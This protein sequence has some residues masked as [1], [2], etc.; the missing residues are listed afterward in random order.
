M[1]KTENSDSKPSRYERLIGRVE[2]LL[3]VTP[4]EMRPIASV[5]V[6]RA[7]WRLDADG[8]PV[9]KAC[10]RLWNGGEF[11]L[12]AA[13]I[14]TVNGWESMPVCRYSTPCWYLNDAPGAGDSTLEVVYDTVVRLLEEYVAD[15]EDEKRRKARR[16][17]ARKKSKLLRERGYVKMWV[18]PE[19]MKRLSRFLSC[20]SDSPFGISVDDDVVRMSG[21]V[22]G[23]SVDDDVVRVSG[24]GK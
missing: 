20:T 8:N 10:V 1:K 12:D 2:A 6:Q 7:L 15:A 23:I 13:V 19:R 3:D 24:A 9:G 22:F 11:A 21:S 16:A 17:A 18:H 14:A 5:M 4:D